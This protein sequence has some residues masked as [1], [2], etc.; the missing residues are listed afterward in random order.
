MNFISYEYISVSK[1]LLWEVVFMSIIWLSD[2]RFV[3]FPDNNYYDIQESL[4]Y[5]GYISS[6]RMDE[7]G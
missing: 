3:L 1:S 6:L 5:F 2:P 7:S 4:R